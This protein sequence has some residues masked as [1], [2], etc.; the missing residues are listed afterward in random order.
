MKMIEVP[1]F[2]DSTVRALHL[3]KAVEFDNCLLNIFLDYS[4]T[5]NVRG[6]WQGKCGK[7]GYPFSG[8]WRLSDYSLKIRYAYEV[9]ELDD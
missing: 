9:T 3:F 6:D 5:Q 1:R 4:K 8:H 2:R 7:W